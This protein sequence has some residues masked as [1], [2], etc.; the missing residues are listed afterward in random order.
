MAS[1]NTL[2]VEPSLLDEDNLIQPDEMTAQPYTIPD[3][4]P[5][6]FSEPL[7]PSVNKSQATSA[8]SHM[9]Q[10]NFYRSY[11]NLDTDTFLQKIQ[12]ASNPLNSAF[13]GDEDTDEV[14]ELY[15]FFW[16]T[17]TLIFLMFVSATGSNILANWL[18]SDPENKPYE[19]SFELLSKSIF[20]FYGY[21]LVV[22]LILYL[23]TAFLLKFPNTL[24]L[25]KVISIYGYTNILWFPITAINF[26]IVVFISNKKHHLM[27]NFLEWIIVLISGTITGLSN[28]TKLSGVIHK[29][30][31]LLADGDASSAN[32]QYMTI[33]G[34]L[35]IAHALF[36][37]LVKI[38]FFGIK[39]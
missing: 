11:F 21:N 8:K 17:G 5:A 1:Y 20:L 28:I 3:S 6:P 25:T 32:R 31:L 36:T 12:R 14:T 9:F 19:Y 39:V 30:C 7:Q 26:L 4:S 37:I 34:L 33:I 29:N 10:I 16:I 38:S 2:P 27:L 35:V 24:P 15:G 23:G 13:A 22:P 18:H